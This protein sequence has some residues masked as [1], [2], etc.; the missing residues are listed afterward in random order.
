MILAA[1]LEKILVVFRLMILNE[2]QSSILIEIY[3]KK[4]ILQIIALLS[5]LNIIIKI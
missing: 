5:K 3:L 1:K 2:N 4:L